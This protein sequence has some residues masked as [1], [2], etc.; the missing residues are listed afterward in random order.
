MRRVVAEVGRSLAGDVV[1]AELVQS[2][3]L[4]GGCAGL[5]VRVWVAGVVGQG[6]S[7]AVLGHVVADVGPARQRRRTGDVRLRHH[8]VRARVGGR[9]DHVAG[10]AAGRLKGC[11]YA[12]GRGRRDVGGKVD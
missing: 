4:V 1:L 2:V 8:L 7:G 5:R 12:G 6:F 10:P 9:C 11:H 3:V